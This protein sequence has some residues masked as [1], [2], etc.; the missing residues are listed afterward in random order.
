M[1]MLSRAIWAG[2]ELLAFGAFETKLCVESFKLMEKSI[3]C[4]YYCYYWFWPKGFLS[5]HR[6]TTEDQILLPC[7]MLESKD[8]IQMSW[9]LAS[10]GTYRVKHFS[11]GIRTSIWTGKSPAPLNC[12]GA[13]I[14]PATHSRVLRNTPACN[15]NILILPLFLCIL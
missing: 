5:S 2:G 11:P 7:F 10:G 8:N 14:Y 13:K 9:N 6:S 12:Q 1:C 3:L 15:D 4:H